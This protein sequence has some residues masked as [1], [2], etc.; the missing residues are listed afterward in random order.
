MT[1]REFAR[2]YWGGEADFAEQ[3]YGVPDE[4][5]EFD[6]LMESDWVFDAWSRQDSSNARAYRLLEKLDLGPDFKGEDAVGEI[7]FID[8]PHPGSDY[9]GVEAA[10]QVSISLLQRRLTDLGTNIRISLG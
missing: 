5:I 10:N 3:F 7:R 9:L 1:I 6:E 8:G 2:R 4:E